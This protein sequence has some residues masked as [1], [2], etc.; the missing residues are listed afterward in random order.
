MFESL[1]M[2]TRD[3]I[4]VVAVIAG[5]IL[6]VQAQQFIESLREKK[7]RRSEIFKKLMSTRAERVNREHVQALNMIDIEFYGRKLFGVRYQTNK[8]KSVTNAWKNYNDKLNDLKSYTSQE[9]WQKEIDSLFTIL[10]YKMSIALGYEYDEVQLKRDCYR[11]QVHVDIENKQLNVITGLADLL[12]SRRSLPVNIT[13][14]STMQ[15]KGDQ[16]INAS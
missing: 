11:P 4:T 12:D 15:N 5:P 16:K 13:E 14:C 2:Q 9:L 8:E 1:N 3:W 10:L 6:A 7:K